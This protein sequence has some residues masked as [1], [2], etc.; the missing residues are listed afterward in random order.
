MGEL[1]HWILL[2]QEY[3]FTVV[4]RAGTDNAKVDCLSRYPLPSTNGAPLPDLAKG[5]ILALASHFS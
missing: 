5:E 1:V 4:H 2:L 3:D